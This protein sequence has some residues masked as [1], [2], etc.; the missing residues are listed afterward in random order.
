M[1]EADVLSHKLETLHTDVRKIEQ[2]LQDLTVAITRLAIVEERQSTTAAALERA[3][4]A[5][6]KIEDRVAII[7][8]QVP[9]NRKLSVWID[10][11]TW[12][13][14]GLLGMYLIKSL[15]VN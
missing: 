4:K 6:E 8:L 15:G 11:V 10:R 12:A 5:L 9:A 3:F 1:A 13:A 7:E 14:L 2:V